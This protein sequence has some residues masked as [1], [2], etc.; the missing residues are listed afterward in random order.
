MAAILRFN[1]LKIASG[2]RPR[3]LRSRER[4]RARIWDACS[5]LRPARQI[6]KPIFFIGMPRSGTTLMF[7]TLA[8]HPDLAWFSQYLERAPAVAAVAALSRLVDRVP[9]LRK[10]VNRHGESRSR[11]GRLR[12]APDE[13]YAVWERCCGERFR[14]D[15]LLGAR[16]SEA[17][18]SCARRMVGRVM[19]YQGKPRF[20][21][22]ITGPARIGYLSS[23]FEDARF[24]HIVRDGRAVVDSLMSVPFWKESKR[25]RE[26]AW[27]GGLDA[28]EIVSWRSRG[29]SPPEL[30]AIQWRTV[31]EA[32]RREAAD[33]APDRYREVRY[34]DFVADPHASLDEIIDFCALPRDQRPHAFIDDRAG[35]RNLND[36]WRQRLSEADR[37]RLEAVLEA[38]LRDL[39]YA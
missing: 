23:I 27:R 25:M 7:T 15:Y 20:A 2:A 19:R 35:V 34:E 33:L 9:S 37:E 21:A 31:I 5:A 30:A 16:A 28:E 14:Y 6:D 22:K 3:H 24:V 13:A 10:P 39:G 12:I 18:R 1:N 36:R 4:R 32:A 38:P 26:P 8:V 29:A 17:E 11:L